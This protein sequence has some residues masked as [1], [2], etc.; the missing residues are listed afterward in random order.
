MVFLRS[1]LLHYPSPLREKIGR[2]DAIKKSL[3][4]LKNAGL[5]EEWQSWAD[6]FITVERWIETIYTSETNRAGKK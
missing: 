1:G 6:E 4:E 3:D 5:P 2:R